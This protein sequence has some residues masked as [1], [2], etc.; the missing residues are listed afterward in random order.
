MGAGRFR[1]SMLRQRLPQSSPQAI[2]DIPPAR[3]IRGEDPHALLGLLRL[4]TSRHTLP[5]TYLLDLSGLGAEVED[6]GD[7]RRNVAGEPLQHAL[8]CLHSGGKMAGSFLQH[9]F[10]ALSNAAFAQVDR[11]DDQF[12][13]CWTSHVQDEAKL[14]SPVVHVTF[15]VGEEPIESSSLPGLVRGR[16]VDAPF[17]QVEQDFGRDVSGDRRLPEGIKGRRIKPLDPLGHSPGSQSTQNADVMSLVRCLE[18]LPLGQ[19]GVNSRQ[20]EEAPVGPVTQ[21]LSAGSEF[22]HLFPGVGI[23]AGE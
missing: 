3:V 6:Q 2:S 4:G 17:G 20:R 11:H 12:I 7:Q 18:G 21:F 14:G 19:D 22:V 15:E 16:D 23:E 13:T 1:G 10:H 5:G 9:G 8:R